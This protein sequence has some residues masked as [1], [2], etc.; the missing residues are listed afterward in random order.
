LL[1]QTLWGR[2]GGLLQLAISFTLRRYPP[3][4]AE[5]HVL[6]LMY[7]MV[8]ACN[9]A[10]DKRRWRKMSPIVDKP[11]RWS[12]SALE[13]WAYQ[14]QISVTDTSCGKPP[15]YSCRPPRGSMFL[16]LRAEQTLSMLGTGVLWRWYWEN[17]NFIPP[18]E[19]SSL[20]RQV[21]SCVEHRVG[22]SQCRG[23][24]TPLLLQLVYTSMRIVDGGSTAPTFWSFV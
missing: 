19:N 24:W 20:N 4:D 15:V 8:Q 3:S 16:Y 17:C 12:T 1:S 18:E 21:Q 7:C 6:V 23:R 11:D 22:S 5:H 10:R 13:T 14:Y 9:M 2:P